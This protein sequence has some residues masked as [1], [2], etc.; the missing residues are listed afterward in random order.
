[1]SL[2]RQA[3]ILV[4]DDTPAIHEDFTKILAERASSATLEN[5]RAGFWGE[6][7]AIAATMP[8]F[9]VQHA[10][11]GESGARLTAEAVRAGQPFDVAFVDMR[12]PPG[13]DG[14]RTIQ[15]LWQLDPGLQIVICTAY[16]DHSLEE[17][18]AR[19]GATDALLVLKKPCDPVEVLQLACTLA[20]KRA[21]QA[22]AGLRHEELEQLV[23]ARTADLLAATERAEAAARAKAEFLANMSHEIRTP[24]TAM[25]GYSDLLLDPQLQPEEVASHVRTIRR[26]GMHLLAILNDILDLSRI[27]A[28][29]MTIESVECSP[30]EI[31]GEVVDLL[32]L[33]AQEKKLSLSIEAEG[34]LPVRISSDPT[35]LRQVLVNL[36]GNALKFT[37]EGGVTLGARL[38]LEPGATSG[39][40]AFSVRDTGIGMNQEQLD[41]LFQPFVQADASTTR[42]FGGTG[43]GLVIS[44]RLARML[45]G[46]VTV[47][48]SEGQGSTFTLSVPTGPL[49]GVGRVTAAAGPPA[50]VRRADESDVIEGP[51]LAGRVLLAEDTRDSALVVAT[52][53]RRAG[54]EVDVVHDGLSAVQRA[55][56]ALEAERPYGLILMDMHMPELDGFA[57]TRRL[58][59]QGYSLPIVAL[60]ANSMPEDCADCLAAGCDSYATKPVRRADLLSLVALLLQGQVG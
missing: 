45:G 30:L 27:E 22:Q 29:C 11:Q 51:R 57:A 3:R 44:R 48:S 21:L 54:A 58:R 43:L 59:E 26:N 35:R 40:L 1:M 8:R 4:V 31:L 24:L 55:L 41:R 6:S 16:S 14:L 38:E 12:M 10:E 28:G 7:G 33:R 37:S 53:L 25:L 47:S 5:A 17:I 60:T 56:A 9:L 52:I 2:D 34:A 36:V 39:R 42:R 15:E 19:L 23:A 18:R 32:R 50:R 20:Q 46:D 49:T 13:W